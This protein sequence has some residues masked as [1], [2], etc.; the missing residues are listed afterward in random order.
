MTREE[1]INLIQNRCLSV[2]YL[3]DGEPKNDKDVALK[4]AIEALK[5]DQ[6]QKGYDAAMKNANK[7]KESLIKQYE[8]QIADLNRDN[9][10][11]DFHWDGRG[12]YEES[13]RCFYGD[14]S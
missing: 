2:S 9:S 5:D 14:F 8:K 13:R 7:T 4:M 3:Q 11:W 6:W 10:G 12:D 1:A